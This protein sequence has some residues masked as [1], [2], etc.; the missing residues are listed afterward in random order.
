MTEKVKVSS[1]TLRAKATE[2]DVELPTLPAAPQAPSQL[3]ISHDATKLVI[4]NLE[5]LSQAVKAGRSQNKRLSAMLR[6]AA[7]AYDAADASGKSK[8]EGGGGGPV[9]VNAN[10]PDAVPFPDYRKCEANAPGDNGMDWQEAAREIN[11]TDQGATLRAFVGQLRMK[12]TEFATLADKFTMAGTEWEGAAAEEAEKALRKYAEWL[13]GMSEST[14]KLAD[15]ANRLAEIHSDRCFEH[16]TMADVAH[17]EQAFF[18]QWEFGAKTLGMSEMQERSD[19][20]RK[21]YADQTNFQPINPPQLTDLGY[22]S[23]PVNPG[24]VKPRTGDGTQTPGGGPPSGGGGGGTPS[25]GQPSTPEMPSSSPAGAGAQKPSGSGSPSGGSPSGGGAPSGGSGQGAPSGGMPGGMGGDKP[26]MPKLP[27]GP[28]VSPASAGG[29]AGGGSAG[30]GGG[31]LGGQPMQPAAVAPALGGAG[32]AA[33][34]GA[35]QAAGPA[36]VG[37]G[38]GGGMGGMGHG[39]NREGGKEKKRNAGLS[40][41]EVLYTEDRAFTDGVIGHRRRTKIDDKKETK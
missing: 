41:D 33:A 34:G 1:E 8:I 10:L 37:G 29:G 23:P 20:V 38:M 22:Q 18:E 7:D 11:S 12:A 6:A 31:G 13:H 28:G 21:K 16:P 3:K 26:E 40:P 36:P 5:H 9:P 30:G 4:D 19:N 25:G 27:D 2:V 14:G 32:G 15:Q 17:F 24:D 35:S 39:G